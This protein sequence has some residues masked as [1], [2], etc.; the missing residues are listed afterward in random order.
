MASDLIQFNV[1]S[2]GFFSFSFF[3]SLFENRSVQKNKTKCK[4]NPGEKKEKLSSQ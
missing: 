2:F 4:V 3:G 1:E